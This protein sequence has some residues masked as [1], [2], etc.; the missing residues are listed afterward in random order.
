MGLGTMRE[1]ADYVIEN[2]ESL[3]EARAKLLGFVDTWQP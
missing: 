3:E 2:S 1:S